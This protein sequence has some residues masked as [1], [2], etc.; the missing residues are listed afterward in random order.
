V[1]TKFSGRVNRSVRSDLAGGK[2]DQKFGVGK[3]FRKV[4]HMAP[5]CRP[6]IDSWRALKALIDL[7]E[8]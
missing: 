5:K 4:L 1:V 2:G 6:V 7:L 8:E 3:I